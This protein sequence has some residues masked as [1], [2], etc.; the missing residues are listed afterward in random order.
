[1][2]RQLEQQAALGALLQLAS[3][4]QPDHAVLA[5]VARLADHGTLAQPADRLGQER[6]IGAPDV[7][8]RHR[9]QD[10]QL[11]AQRADQMLIAARDPLAGRTGAGQLRQQVAKIP[12]VADA[13]QQAAVIRFFGSISSGSSDT[14]KCTS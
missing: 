6:A 3:I 11:R 10:R 4:E 2:A 5:V 8:Q 7:L 1:M 14:L 12:R 13:R 9:F